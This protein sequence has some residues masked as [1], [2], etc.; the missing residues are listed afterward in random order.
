M[1]PEPSSSDHRLHDPPAAKR[2]KITSTFQRVSSKSTAGGRVGCERSLEGWWEQKTKSMTLLSLLLR[3]ALL[4]STCSLS[5]LVI[6]V[7]ECTSLTSLKCTIQGH[8]HEA[9]QPSLLPSPGMLASPQKETPHP[10]ISHCQPRTPT[11]RQALA[12]RPPSVSI[13]LPVRDN[14]HEQN[15]T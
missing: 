13:R 7:T 8:P 1:G 2:L 3:Q 10:L 4:P 9:M 14:R 15:H 11:S 5:V 12:T 6:R